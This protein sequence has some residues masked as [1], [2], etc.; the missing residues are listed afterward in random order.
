M[1]SPVKD[2][3]VTIRSLM[4]W[5]RSNISASLAY[6]SSPFP[7]SANALGVLPPLWSRAAMNPRPFAMCSICWL[8][9]FRPPGRPT[10]SST[11]SHHTQRLRAALPLERSR[12]GG[13][14]SGEEALA[15]EPGAGVGVVD[16]EVGV[17]AAV[18][19]GG[20]VLDLVVDEPQCLAREA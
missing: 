7:Y 8:N 1:C 4:A 19:G 3:L 20:D 14:N 10:T 5:T 17:P 2:G 12:P 6:A 13:P 16:P 15:R 9:M 18:R 11:T